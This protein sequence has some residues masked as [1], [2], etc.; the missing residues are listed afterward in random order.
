MDANMKIGFFDSG[1]GGLTVLREVV[2]HL[3]QYDYIYFGDTANLPYGD[4][5]ENE[6]YEL[7]KAAITELFD[8][9]CLIV[10]VACNTA[11]S[12]TL[13]K[14]Q[15]TFLKASYP[16]RR[17]LGVIIPTLEVLLEQTP[18][19][20]ILLATKRTVESGKYEV[21][22]KKLAPTQ[23]LLSIP[24]VKLVPL[25]EAQKHDEAFMIT[26]DALREVQTGKG[27][28][29]ILGCTHYTLLKDDLRE[30]F[31]NTKFLSQDEIIPDKLADYLTRHP[32]L[33]SRL[34]G[35]G[36]RTIHL[37][38]LRNDYE[39]LAGQ[40]LGGVYMPHES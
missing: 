10:V 9:D 33:S 38:E 25:I 39:E 15:D 6:I 23:H 21:E 16:D 30:L 17:V 4:K 40:F 36:E 14:L 20:T 3:P 35:T 11:S 5:T 8:R 7:T 19:R 29:V 13:R 24:M 31:P 27:D 34:S 22:L 28:V 18:N 12:E 1:L 37:T 26:V 32:E 2:K